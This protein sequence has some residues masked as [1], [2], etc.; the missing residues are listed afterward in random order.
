MSEDPIFSL[1]KA[2]GENEVAFDYVKA[3]NFR[4]VWV[5]GAIGAITPRGLIHCALYAERASIPRR[6]V[7]QIETAGDNVSKLGSEVIEKQIDR[8]S[9]VR[10]MSLDLMMTAECAENL[11]RWLL[12][13]AE[14]LRKVESESGKAKE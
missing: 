2:A 12:E 4:V 1:D 8:G 3:P 11:A 13:R 10:E 7:F 14:E 9:I 6:Q 5:D